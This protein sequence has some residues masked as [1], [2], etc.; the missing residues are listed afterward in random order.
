MTRGVFD[1]TK[2]ELRRINEISDAIDANVWDA[3]RD[4]ERG[5]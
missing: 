2:H 4:G 1:F 3:Q 5:A